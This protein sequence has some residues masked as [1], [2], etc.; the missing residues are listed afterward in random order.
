VTVAAYARRHHVRTRQ[1]ESGAGMVE[2]A[3]GPPDGVVTAF[4]RRR[5]RRRHVVHRRHCVGVI[6]LMARYARGATQ[7]VIVIDM[8]IGALPRRHRVR[9]AE[10]ET[11]AAVIERRIR[12]RGC[13]VALL[14]ALREI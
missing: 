1:L 4:A 10:R 7:V 8:A 5:E 14:A 2:C 13:V 3:I 6:G 12:P 9:S 11:G